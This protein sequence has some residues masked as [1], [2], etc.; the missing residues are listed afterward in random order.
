[1]P[2]GNS[3]ILF[4]D[5]GWSSV[6]VYGEWSEDGNRR[7]TVREAEFVIEH[8]QTIELSVLYNA[9]GVDKGCKM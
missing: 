3:L 1:M 5:G 9:V 2:I 4:S 8:A 6:E 7:K